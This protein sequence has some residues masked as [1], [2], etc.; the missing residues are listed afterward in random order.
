MSYKHWY[1]QNYFVQTY[2]KE[3][4][5]SPGT[6]YPI[7][8][9]R[10]LVL[11]CTK[12][13]YYKAFSSF[14]ESHLKQWSNSTLHEIINQVQNH[15][16]ISSLEDPTFILALWDN[17]VKRF[18][19][20][21]FN[22]PSI[23]IRTKEQKYIELLQVNT[24]FC[25]EDELK[26]DCIDLTIIDILFM[27]DS[28]IAY[29]FYKKMYQ[30]VHFKKDILLLLK[31]YGIPEHFDALDQF[32]IFANQDH[33][34]IKITHNKSL[35][36]KL[37][38]LS[39]YETEFDHLL[40]RY[41]DD[42]NRNSSASI[43]LHEL[44]MNAYE[45]GVLALD[46]DEKQ[47]A[48]DKGNYFEW[49]EN[50]EKGVDQDINISI[51]IY[52]DNT[53]RVTV[54]D[55]GKGFDYSLIDQYVIDEFDYHGRGIGMIAQMIDGLFY[56]KNGSQ[57][58]FFLRFD[59]PIWL[60]YSKACYDYF[61]TL[62]LLAIGEGTFANV[63][64]SLGY[65]LKHLLLAKDNDDLLAL[66]RSERPTF[67]FIDLE[68]FDRSLALAKEL[69]SILGD[70][71]FILSA[72]RYKQEHFIQ[73]I[74]ENIDQIMLCE[75]IGSMLY[76]AMLQSLQNRLYQ[77]D[78]ICFVDKDDHEDIRAQ[79]QYFKEQQNKAF[80]KQKLVIH[81]DSKSF[82]W[83]DHELLYRPMEILSGDIYS[84]FKVGEDCF[85][86]YIIDSMGK[87]ISASVTAILSAAFMNRAITLSKEHEDFG[88]ERVVRDFVG[89]VT[90]NLLEEEVLSCSFVFV[91]RKTHTLT[92]VSFGMYP[93]L[94]KD[95]NSD[96]TKVLKSPHPPLMN[97]E[98]PYKLETVSLPK[99]FE[100]LIYSDGL[101]E[102]EE[103]TIEN[104]I[105]L[106][107]HSSSYV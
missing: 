97:F 3:G 26:V 91:N 41:F 77:G 73:A 9:D 78:D 70:I 11:V 76:D 44:L 51:D 98:M 40:S 65:K 104:L 96:E 99:H 60:E 35:Q 30:S 71:P 92:H 48:M 28:L 106:F 18:C 103:F 74:S 94:I 55:F 5:N 6:I 46:P 67:V 82:S 7:G 39:H 102:M 50:I 45:Y 80:E 10:L 42:E 13:T 53:L 68:D 23:Q 16:K 12:K 33:N 101:C 29:E 14:L 36:A 54:D 19:S 52:T 85:I 100:L 21:N 47:A 24:D 107:A 20:C 49:I 90:P 79:N 66:A 83:L 61:K 69:K 57:V 75:N 37:K 27:S 105:K 93:T 81:D 89:F 59:T 43:V 34:G 86:S 63:Q 31:Y 25:K 32:L 62:R 64:K 88:L 22:L 72:Q 84:V 2:D 17:E 8:K 87:G 4:P 58:I 95:R 56:T 15:F 1:Q 38:P